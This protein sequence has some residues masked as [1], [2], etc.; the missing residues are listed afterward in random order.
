MGEEGVERRKETGKVG[1]QYIL[2]KGNSREVVIDGKYQSHRWIHIGKTTRKRADKEVFERGSIQERP[3]R[4]YRYV[5][6]S[7]VGF[8]ATFLV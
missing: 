5:P 2:M 7:K 4:K 6:Y 3:K 1:R 8:T